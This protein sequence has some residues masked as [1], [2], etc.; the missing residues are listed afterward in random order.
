[1]RR[2]AAL[3][4]ALGF[5]IAGLGAPPVQAEEPPPNAIISEG[6][7]AAVFIGYGGDRF[8]NLSWRPSKQYEGASMLYQVK[9]SD[10]AMLES[11]TAAA[12][13]RDIN[14]LPNTTYGYTLITYQSLK[15]TYVITKGPSK[16]QAIT[17]TVTKR[18]G[19]NAINVVTLPSM[20]VNLRVAAISPDSFTLT[21]EPPQYM[22]NPVTYSV[23]MG[24]NVMAYGLTSGSYTATG[25]TS[26]KSYVTVVVVENVT[27]Q[28][29]KNA[30]LTPQTPKA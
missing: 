19:R 7:G 28:A 16:G 4:L 1:M 20:V 23:V 5:V 17:R 26:N 29:P 6:N 21:W 25:L 8:V 15:K 18:V 24:G 27:G 9:R 12:S 10:G 14:L 30:T 22:A 11:L 3:A 2:V 13:F